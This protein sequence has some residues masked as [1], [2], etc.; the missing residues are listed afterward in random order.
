MLTH[1]CNEKRRMGRHSR[2]CLHHCPGARKL[3]RGQHHFGIRADHQLQ[4]D[5]AGQQFDFTVRDHDSLRGWSSIR[6]VDPVGHKISSE[7][8]WPDTFPCL[9]PAYDFLTGPLA[10]QSNNSALIPDILEQ[11][12]ILANNLA[13]A[14]DTPTGI[15]INDIFFDPPRTSNATTNG[16]A[17]A[18]TL[19]LE[20]TRLSDLTGNETYA[21]LTQ[22]AES[23]F[24]HPLNPAL[25]EPFPG[26]IGDTIDINTG[27]FLTGSGGWVGGSD[28]FYEYLIK[29]YLYDP[30][31]F[32][33]Y[34]DRWVEAAESTIQNLASHPTTNTN[35]TFL[36]IYSN[37]TLT[38]VSQH[39]EFPP[40][41][42]VLRM[43]PF[44]Q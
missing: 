12:T 35:L 41:C 43:T 5:N 34:K 4:R 16:P 18:G 30:V 24:L 44:C 15:P 39:C 31:R 40:S 33:S 20:W 17:G 22:K 8:S 11:V 37:T 32:S 27:K 13:V 1:S 14:F 36:A 6:Y 9:L 42:P 25:G 38:Y 2:G 23:Y 21:R 10:T 19:V 29:M 3:G 7:R 28:S 26:L